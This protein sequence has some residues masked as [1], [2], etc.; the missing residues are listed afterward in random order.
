MLPS[1]GLLPEAA[2]GAGADSRGAAG[3]A[4]PG[5]SDSPFRAELASQS[6][7]HKEHGEDLAASGPTEQRC[8]RLEQRAQRALAR[9]RA[10]QES[11]A[12][13]QLEAA[14]PLLSVAGA[15][16]PG[17][18][19]NE[20]ATAQESAAAAQRERCAALELGLQ[21]AGVA[22]ALKLEAVD[23]R[24]ETLLFEKSEAEREL[25]ETLAEYY[26]ALREQTAETARELQE[27]RVQN[28][29]ALSEQAIAKRRR[30][31]KKR[32]PG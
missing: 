19:Y 13:A 4:E 16:D 14:M 2:A 25:Q 7:E 26:A 12:A 3:A 17:L 20:A 1:L 9:R 21:A 10:A 27:A 8:L 18:V 30:P 24:L 15:S 32:Q 31:K 5:E 23:R 22:E 6:E 29:A 28:S 11:A